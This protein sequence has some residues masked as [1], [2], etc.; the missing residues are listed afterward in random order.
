M[1]S[2]DLLQVYMYVVE[3]KSVKKKKQQR[4]TLQ[5]NH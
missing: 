2:V 3:I 5:N 4:T 1:T